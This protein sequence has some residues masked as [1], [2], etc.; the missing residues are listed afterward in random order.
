[1]YLR[2]PEY[3]VL[4]CGCVTLGIVTT[5]AVLLACQ[6]LGIDVSK[7]VWVM[8]IPTLLSLGANV[9]TIELYK[10]VRGH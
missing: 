2:I 9:L 6:Y 4:A 3:I 7:N 10:K 8:A 1:M 5:F